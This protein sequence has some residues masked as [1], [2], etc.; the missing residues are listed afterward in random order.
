[1]PRSAGPRCNPMRQFTAETSS[2]RL[3]PMTDIAD[4]RVF[5]AGAD[6]V[7][8]PLFALV[9]S[10]LGDS[11]TVRADEIDRGVTTQLVR[12][13]Q[14]S[15][16]FSL[17]ALFDA[18]PSVAIARHLWRRLIQAWREASRAAEGEQLTATLFAIPVV[19]VVGNQTSSA[20]PPVDA[21]LNDLD[22]IGAIL[23]EHRA[24]GGSETFALA[25]ALAAPDAIALARL[26]ALLRWQRAT[27]AADAQR[28]L[29]P[30]P[31]A[32]P[33]GHEAAHL[34]FIVGTALAAP[35]ID[36]LAGTNTNGWALPLAQELGRQLAVPGASVL[37][38]PR[39]PASPPAALQQG[40]AAQRAVSAQLFASNAIRRLR[41][42]VGEP[43]AVISAHRCAAAPGGGELRL[44]LSSVFDPRQAEG[45]RCPL[46]PTETAGDVAS[47]LI[48]LLHDCRVSDV[49]LLDGIHADRDA[50]TGLTLLFKSDTVPANAA[51]SLH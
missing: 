17:A 41:A 47:M 18:A 32:I 33:A 9:A 36:L 12:C 1:M 51:A 10:S 19:I 29:A 21:V 42:G 40:R 44:S 11:S 48:E 37:A 20:L 38:L 43:C 27:L 5:P 4:P 7:Y 22:R 31:I 13:L 35:H 30:A 26:P 34:R 24:I 14:D 3:Q 15:D 25:S 49:R 8:A 28:D 45:F 6:T 2:P 23:R 46:F 50:A 39:A 16:G